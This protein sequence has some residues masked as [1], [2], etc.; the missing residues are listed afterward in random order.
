[1]LAW[2]VRVA[3]V[4]AVAAVWWLPPIPD[5]NTETAT[6]SAYEARMDLSREGEL[7][8]EETITVVLPGGKRGIFRIFDTASPRRPNVEHPVEVEVVER[9]GQPEPYTELD[10]AEGTTTIRIGVE[11]RF[12]PA[13]E[14]TY[15]IVSSTVDVLEPGEPGETLWWWDVVGSGWQMPMAASSVSV[16]LPA[17]PLRAEC[18]IGDGDQPCATSLEGTSLRVSTGPLEPFTPV[19]VRVAFDADDVAA[20]IEGTVDPDVVRSLLAA[21]IALAVALGLW[22]ANRERSPAFPVLFEPPFMVPPALGVKVLDEEHSD[23]D[24][25]AT[26]FDLAERGVLRL[27]GGTG[28]TWYVEVVQALEAEHLHPLE[29]QLLAD[30]GLSA[31]GDVFVVA[32]TEGSGRTVATARATLRAQV[33][34]A[35]GGYLSASVPGMVGR[36]LGWICLGASVLMVGRYFID[37]G[38]VR[39][40]LLAGTSTFAVAAMGMLTARGVTTRRTKEGRDLWSRTGG[41]ARFMTTDS[42]EARFDAAARLEWYPRYLAWAVALGVG[43][44]WARRYEAQGVDVPEVPWIIWTGTGP[45]TGQ[46]FSPSSMSRSFDSAI[47][48]AAATYAAAEAA[49]SSSSGGGGGFSGGSGGGG[50]GG[51]SW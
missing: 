34:Q 16:Q 38:W 39:W 11:D 7:L 14:H 25:Q 15:R 17:E 49:R 51:G 19:T 44:E 20:P 47:V 5:Q 18:V 43:D 22:A 29:Q 48:S 28:D 33:D 41:F 23:A 40:P 6:I 13:G 42:A 26:L 32:P 1:V 10:G 45:G 36:S 12:L 46:R 24:L 31:V 50:G 27:R 21:L 8:A 35:S 9:D 3:L 2:T 4:L 30:L 37:D